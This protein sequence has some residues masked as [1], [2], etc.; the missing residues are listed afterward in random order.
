VTRPA[1][2][3][4]KWI[5]AWP[6]ILHGRGIEAAEDRQAAAGPPSNLLEPAGGEEHARGR[7]DL[8]DITG[9]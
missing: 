8:E 1:D 2:G 5:V 4:V 6:R 3:S 7:H 9:H